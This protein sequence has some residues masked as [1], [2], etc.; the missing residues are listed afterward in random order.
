MAARSMSD[1]D[2][3][4]FIKWKSSVI[5]IIKITISFSKTN[6]LSQNKTHQILSTIWGVEFIEPKKEEVADE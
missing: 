3:V 1:P 6:F 2:V 5:T 4:D